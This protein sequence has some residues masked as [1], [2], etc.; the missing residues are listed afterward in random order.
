[1]RTCLAMDCFPKK[2]PEVYLAS[3]VTGGDDP[4]PP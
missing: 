3:P 1:M 4:V 2:N